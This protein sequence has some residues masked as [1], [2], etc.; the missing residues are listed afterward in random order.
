MA[1]KRANCLHFCLFRK[2][3]TMAIAKA[4]KKT[5]TNVDVL[6]DARKTDTDGDV[7]ADAIAAL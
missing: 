4:A 5:D 1:L 3:H 2:L 7:L 6:T